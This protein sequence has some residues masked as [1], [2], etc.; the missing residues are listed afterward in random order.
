M[1]ILRGYG[2]SPNLQRLLQQYW[3]EKAMV[4]NAGK[5]F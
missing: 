3:E 5:C 2:L 4:L 1:E